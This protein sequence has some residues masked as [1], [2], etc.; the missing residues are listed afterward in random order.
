MVRGNVSFSRAGSSRSRPRRNSASFQAYPVL[1]RL[2]LPE[3]I[4]G[5][6]QLR[7]CGAKQLEMPRLHK[8]PETT[9]HSPETSSVSQPV[10]LLLDKCGL[11]ASLPV[12]RTLPLS[13][14]G[15]IG[16]KLSRTLEFSPR[17]DWRGEG[18]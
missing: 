10:P 11:V 4:V 15:L 7:L 12:R 3:G 13:L 1:L 14:A 6:A 17:F 8:D 2:E 16:S 5:M 18:I 9:D